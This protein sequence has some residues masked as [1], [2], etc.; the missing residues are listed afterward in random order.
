MNAGT[1]SMRN[2]QRVRLGGAGPRAASAFSDQGRVRRE[3]LD[4]A[5]LGNRNVHRTR[6]TAI[7]I[8]KGGLP[9][10]V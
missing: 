3:G 5:S 1:K 4:V 10:V 8:P 9:A 7:V 2:R 6:A